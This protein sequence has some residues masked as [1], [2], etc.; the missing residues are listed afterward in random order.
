MNSLLFWVFWFL[1]FVIIFTLNLLFPDMVVLG[2]SSF[3]G[4]SS[5]LISS[6]WVT[7]VV[8]SLWEY[9][10]VRNVN[11]DTQEF[12]YSYSLFINILGVWLVSRYSQYTGIGMFSFGWV[13]ILGAI[14][15][16]VQ[17]LLIEN[18]GQKR[19]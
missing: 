19:N 5:A 14:A 3:S 10:F 13:I 18:F 8:C 16:L 15:T 1:E 12:F 7:F 2:N 9:M 17:K 6:F 4:L 11:F